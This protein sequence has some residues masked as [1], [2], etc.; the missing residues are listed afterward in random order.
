MGEYS[1]LAAK[2]RAMYGKLLTYDNYK[3]LMRQNSVRD[4]VSYLKHNTHYKDV[5]ADANESDIHRAQFEKILRKSM[6]NDYRKLFC[7]A[8]GNVKE[9][10]K[11]AY[12]G[13]E[14]ESLKR[15]FRVLETEGTPTLVED[16]LLFLKRYDTLN[17]AKLS[18]MQNTQEF[19]TNLKG[20]AYYE[21]LRPFLTVNEN[22]N[23]FRI[24]MSLDMYY[25]DLVFSKKKNLL[26]GIDAKI[27]ERSLGT[28][29][30]VLNLLWIFRG[31][32][33]YNIDR[34]VILSYLIPHRYKISMDLIYDLVDV[35]NKE[36]F[37]HIVSNTKYS[38]LFSPDD[39]R[40]FDLKFSDYMYRLH[41]SLLKR[42]GY[43]ISC[44]I[45]YLHLKEFEIS[46]VISIIE[47]IRYKMPVKT[48][49]TYVIGMSTK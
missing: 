48:I 37:L 49:S 6:L 21:V 22:H 18:K 13:H 15:L 12:L 32:I 46:N 11:V 33:I 9:F 23:L 25:I 27:I 30:D 16:S 36:Q 35:K 3:E 43:S 8:Q 1:A 24:E 28:E 38:H 26:S 44:A 2:T 31:R 17:I 10:I 45:S 7:F 20:T 34:S 14:I 19:I 39:S 5:L 42:Y 40:L 4:I 29:I 47:G 41:R